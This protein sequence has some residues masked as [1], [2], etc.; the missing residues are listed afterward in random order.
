MNCTSSQIWNMYLSRCQI[1]ILLKEKTINFSDKKNMVTKFNTRRYVCSWF[2]GLMLM[3][4]NGLNVG[5]SLWHSMLFVSFERSDQGG[6]IYRFRILAQKMRS[7]DGK[8][9]F[10]P[11]FC[12]DQRSSVSQLSRKFGNCAKKNLSPFFP[13]YHWVQCQETRRRNF[14]QFMKRVA[15]VAVT[16]LFSW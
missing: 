11:F 8:I 12:P 4:L 14:L 2:S 7:W 10:P 5:C 1:R 9:N 3:Q 13:L 16:Q 15:Q 6:R